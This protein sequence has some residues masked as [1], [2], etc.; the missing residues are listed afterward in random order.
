VHRLRSRPALASLVAGL[1]TGLSGLVAPAPARAQAR[2]GVTGAG[3]AEAGYSREASREATRIVWDTWGVPHVY[4]PTDEAMGYAFGWAQAREHGNAILRLY[5]LARGRGAEYWGERYLASDR[6]VRELGLPALGARQVDSLPAKLARYVRAFAAGVDAYARAH[7]EAIADSVR[8]VLPVTAGD[9]LAHQDRI[10]FTFVAV[11]G[12][13][14]PIVGLDGLPPAA[15]AAEPGSNTWAIGPRRSASGHAMLLQNP[16]LPWDPDLMH[17]TEAQLSS[18]AGEVYG[19]TLIGL[20]QIAIG[21]NADLGWSHTVNT[22]DA[23]DSYT[24]RLAPGGYRWEGGVRAF[25]ERLDT[26]RVKQPDGTV[27]SEPFTLRRSVQGPVIGGDDTT[28][29]AVRTTG[30]TAGTVLREWWDMG[31][32][33]DLASFQTALREMALPMFN[34]SYADRDG[35]ILYFYAG[36]VPERSHGDFA[37]W[38]RAL[39]GDSADDVW[40]GVLPFKSLPRIIDPPSDFIQ[41]SNSPPWYATLPRQLDPADYPAYL[42][43]DW[44]DM[45]EHRGLT[46]LMADSSISYDELIHMRYSN[47]M[48]LADRVLPDLLR[49]ARASGDSLA[50]RAAAVLEKWDRAADADSRGAVLF[51]AWVRQAFRNGA[52]VYAH[53]WRS[54]APL[55]TPSGLA[56]PAA[57]ATELS[58][59]AKEVE[60][61]YGSLDVSWGRVH[62]LGDLPGNGAPGDPFGVFHVIAWAPGP[63]GKTERPVHG[64]TWV[65]A[66]EFAPEGPRATAILSYGNA[67]QPGSPHV[68]DQLRLESEKRMRPVWTTPSEVEAH[69]EEVETLDPGGR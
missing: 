35:H 45:R 7:P 43:P 15:P 60:A 58:A 51:D 5:G 3:P 4:A 52:E 57:A 61:R 27:R 64:D 39:P 10:L 30:L 33:H 41:N 12:G 65:A 42:S 47:H 54:D 34:V 21:F 1:L 31:R 32:A 16:H 66:I 2:S 8:S 14:P 44:L 68:L 29:I 36:R 11:T 23:L 53:P 46:M 19:V 24:L 20:P 9:I 6:L 48:G 69:R 59:A 13:R 38:Q 17:F 22:I 56:D 55:A 62:R 18:P 37:Y 28:A 49:A 63:D 26:I 40:T 50:L 25:E 67:T